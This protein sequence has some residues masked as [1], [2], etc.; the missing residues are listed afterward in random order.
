MCVCVCV[1]VCVHQR[2]RE[3]ERIS[4]LSRVVRETERKGE[5]ERERASSLSRVL[6]DRERE[7]ERERG[8]ERE[9]TKMVLHALFK[10]KG[11]CLRIGSTVEPVTNRI[12][13]KVHKL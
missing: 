6:R 4:L 13:Q 1:C 3:R 5:R 2:E 7:R 8:I 9:R 11:Q 10:T 12:K